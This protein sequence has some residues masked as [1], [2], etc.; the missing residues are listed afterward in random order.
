MHQV[1]YWLLGLLFP[2]VGTNLT[3][4]KCFIFPFVITIRRKRFNSCTEGVRM[5]FFIFVK[6]ISIDGISSS[7]PKISLHR[8]WVLNF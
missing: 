6:I 5:I 4:S 3:H 7:F 1:F 8:P 2:L